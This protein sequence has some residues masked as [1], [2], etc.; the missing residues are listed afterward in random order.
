MRMFLLLCFLGIVSCSG[1]KVEPSK[2]DAL[3]KVDSAPLEKS[4]NTFSNQPCQFDANLHYSV[5]YPT[6]FSSKQKLPILILFDPHGDPD[7]P[8]EKYK[9]LANTYDFILI[10]SKESKNGNNPEHTANIVQSM[11]YQCLQIEKVDTN[12]IFAGGFSG[13]ARVAS[14]LALSPS[15]V[16]GLV[17]CGAGIPAGSWTGVPPHLIVGIAGN[18]DMNLSEV[19]N[20]TTHD[21]RM[22]NR[23]QTIRFSGEHA[24]PPSSVME[25]AFIAFTAIAQRDRF[26][27]VNT[28]QLE[29]GLALLKHQADSVSSIIEKVELYKNMVKN[30]QGML[31]TTGVEASLQRLMGSIEY[32][33][34]LSVE[35]EFK[36]IEA[37]N[38]D[39]FLQALG[40]KDTLWWRMEFERWESTK[41][42]KS[43]QAFE[44]M[45]NRIRGVISLSAYMSLSRAVSALHKEQSAYFSSIY[46]L[47][48]PKNSEAWYLS[49]VSAAM[50]GNRSNCIRFLEEAI[51]TG[52][53]DGTRCRIEPA[54]MSLQ[55]DVQFQ[56]KVNQINN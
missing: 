3:S 8:I 47:V 34:G 39:Y 38:R 41:A 9:S 28:K 16:K 46:R 32:K 23:Y 36:Q 35:N 13:G 22:M 20:F 25:N 4:G 55:N 26:T 11:L 37:K 49:A 52:F 33:Q 14:M 10:A 5:Y 42:T 56:E 7:F 53:H 1:K 48:D 44:E 31:N 2:V 27:S 6:R 19:L 18:S 45:K 54:F 17:V 24:W 12:Q 43:P 30:F 50:D 15:G 29:E 40:A 21:P 51:K